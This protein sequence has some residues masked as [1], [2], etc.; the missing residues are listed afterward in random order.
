LDIFCVRPFALHRQQ[1]EKDKQNVDFAPPGKVSA[2]AHD[3]NLLFTKLSE[4]NVP[5][6]C[7]HC[8]SNL[9]WTKVY[10]FSAT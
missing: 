2:D 8:L 6:Y 3:H 5:K 10:G 7:T 9:N 4:G 1:T